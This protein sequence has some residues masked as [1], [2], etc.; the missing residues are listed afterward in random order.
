MRLTKAQ[1][2]RTR[3]RQSSAAS[4]ARQKIKEKKLEEDVLHGRV[5]NRRLSAR[6][7]LIHGQLRAQATALEKR[8]CLTPEIAAIQYPNLYAI[9]ATIQKAKD[10][11]AKDH[12]VPEIPLKMDKY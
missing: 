3:N 11:E 7:D 2:K 9:L 6:I 4:R 5:K 10:E 8:G 1:I 12:S